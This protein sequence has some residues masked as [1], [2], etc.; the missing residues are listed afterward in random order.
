LNVHYHL[1]VPDGVFVK[2]GE[3]LRF[4]MLPVPT[5]LEPWDEDTASWNDSRNMGLE[6]P[7]AVPGC[8]YVD[9]TLSSREGTSFADESPDTTQTTF[10]M[11]AVVAGWVADGFFLGGLAGVLYG[12]T[13]AIFWS[14][15][16]VVD[17]GR[18]RLSVTYTLE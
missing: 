2:D 14:S 7:W 18:P 15:E 6:I 9:G 11:T 12:G 8:G 1:V 13:S 17:G 3:G 16:A 10:P 4:E 5:N